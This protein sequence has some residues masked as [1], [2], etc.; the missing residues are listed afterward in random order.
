MPNGLAD[1][2]SAN[3]NDVEIINCVSHD[4][5][6]VINQHQR[7]PKGG[8]M[9]CR[10]GGKRSYA[11]LFGIE[12]D[13]DSDNELFSEKCTRLR[14]TPVS[15]YNNSVLYDKGIH[16]SRVSTYA[17]CK[18]RFRPASKYWQACC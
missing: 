7:K 9:A 16:A 18:K 13:S 15:P 12:E 8:V 2:R 10:P 11:A 6:T 5:D 4:A 14:S 1:F 3:E 17:D